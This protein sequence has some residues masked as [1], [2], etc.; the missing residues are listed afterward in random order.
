MEDYWEL[1][2]LFKFE[3]NDSDKNSI[4]SEFLIPNHP[5]LDQLD[6]Q[7][8][9][10]ILHSIT[11]KYTTALDKGQ[12][13][14]G[15]RFLNFHYKKTR[16]KKRFLLFVK[17][18]IQSKS[19][20]TKEAKEKYTLNDRFINDWIKEKELKLRR[21]FYLTLIVLFLSLIVAGIFIFCDYRQ[22]FI[23]ALI[24]ILSTQISWLIGKIRPDAKA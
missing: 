6:K 20:M 8:F 21:P 2:R 17:Y 14:E 5:K 13:I 24:G 10:E 16:Y 12:I 19:W 7:I 3:T 22:L 9:N 1:T 4:E 11:L 15:L 18:Y 23:G